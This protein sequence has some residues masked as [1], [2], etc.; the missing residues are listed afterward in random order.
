MRSFNPA[1]NLLA[2]CAIFFCALSASAQTTSGESAAPA[3]PWMLGVSAQVDDLNS[4][5]LYAT[6]NW[7][8]TE[9]T[10]IYLSA[11]SSHYK[12][13]L[14]ELSTQSFLAGFDHLFGR[15][16]FS[17]DVEAWGDSETVEST[18]LRATVH[19]GGERYRF[20]LEMEGQD[21]T[22]SPLRS[23]N[24][25]LDVAGTGVGARLRVNLTD[26]WRLFLRGVSYD[27]EWSGASLPNR[28][29]LT[30]FCADAVA[31]AASCERLQTFVTLLER[32]N[33]FA[34]SSLANNSF[35]DSELSMSMEWD[36]GTKLIGLNYRKDRAIDR[37]RS[38][39]QSLSG[40]ILFPINYRMDLELNL[41]RS[42]S[43]IFRS[44]TY[45]GVFF[46]LYGG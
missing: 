33:L 7:G 26:S 28:D 16:G 23:D 22:L 17:A 4:D 13:R 10:W 25:S 20:Y 43:D 46:L 8:V 3:R 15:F 9:K 39:S 38:E 34:Q 36:V 11:G 5:S 29:S 1:T 18:E 41:G 19:F 32:R 37:D 31:L 14:D 42:E 30:D 44:S 6:F 45:A 21:I 2:T 40:S 24:I 12:D 27:Y 35:V